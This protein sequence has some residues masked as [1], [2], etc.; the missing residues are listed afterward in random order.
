MSSLE[1]GKQQ[2]NILESG[3]KNKEGPRER[4]LYTEVGVIGRGETTLLLWVRKES[5][6]STVVLTLNISKGLHFKGLIP[7]L[8]HH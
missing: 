7:N 1:V 3:H 8:C 4:G 6:V 5:K 2:L